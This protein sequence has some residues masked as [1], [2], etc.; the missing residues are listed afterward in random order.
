MGIVNTC[1]DLEIGTGYAN[2][3]T[4][5]SLVLAFEPS[6]VMDSLKAVT[7]VQNQDQPALVA[8]QLFPAVCM[9]TLLQLH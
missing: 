4:L 3:R 9:D 7:S 5:L 2:H 1:L 8:R 6:G